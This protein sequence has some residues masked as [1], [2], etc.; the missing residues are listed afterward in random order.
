[1]DCSAK[2]AEMERLLFVLFAF[3][4]GKNVCTLRKLL[5]IVVQRDGAAA[6]GARLCEPQHSGGTG[7]VDS[8]WRLE[9]KPGCC[10][11][12]TRA[13][14]NLHELRKLLWIVVRIDTNQ[15]VHKF[16]T[17]SAFAC[18]QRWRHPGDA[19]SLRQ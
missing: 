2:N 16:R 12:Q 8:A 19:N 4:R 10:G 15:A 1:M 7:R 6:K 17:R 9:S 11:S 18:E 3:L 13:P 5:W 14:E